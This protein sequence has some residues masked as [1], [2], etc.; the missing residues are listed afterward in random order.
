M[1]LC[2]DT[3]TYLYE[4]ANKSHLAHTTQAVNYLKTYPDF[5]VSNKAIERIKTVTN[6]KA[7]LASTTAKKDI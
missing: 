2:H 3:W 4:D 7:L 1:K 5:T 6:P